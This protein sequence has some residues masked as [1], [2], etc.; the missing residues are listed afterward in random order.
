MAYIIHT[1]YIAKYIVILLLL[2]VNIQVVQAKQYTGEPI[3]LD[4]QDVDVR[5]VLRTISKY[6]N[7]NII[8]SDKVTG[9]ISLYINDVPYDQAL[10]II[11][12]SKGLGMQKTGNVMYISPTIDIAEKKRQAY[13]MQNVDDVLAPLM[14]RLI[15]L[16][17]ARAEDLERMIEDNS[18][19]ARA[20]KDGKIS[21]DGLLSSR[22]RI[23]VDKRT[24]TLIVN[25]IP[26]SINK[27]LQLVARLDIPV[28]QVLVEARIVVASNS[29]AKELG[30]RWGGGLRSNI[31]SSSL[32]IS[33]SLDGASSMALGATPSLSSRL[34]VDLASTAKNAAGLGLS[35]LGADFLL[36]LELSAMQ[37][38]GR[39]E[40]I[41]SPRVIAQDGGEASIQQGTKIAYNVTDGKGK[42][43]TTWKDI[44]L[45]LRVRP[46]IAPNNQID[47]AL[48]VVKDTPGQVFNGERSVDS[49]SVITKVLVSNGETVVLGG[50]YEQVSA[51]SQNKVPVLGDLPIIGGAFR[52]KQQSV[53]KRELLIFITPK[54]IDP[55][56]RT[57]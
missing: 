5:S 1:K 49:N 41:S 35:L 23:S 54:I 45:M 11:M 27:V 42:V 56:K 12:Q 53:V 33:G 29:F 57:F 19:N 36:D 46:K 48:E 28:K 38:E 43:T 13:E 20:G 8:I 21:T 39:G 32:G 44:P 26:A 31:G 52:H 34:G 37:D 14:Q 47:M 51:H 16:K 30:V 25:D 4:V 9:N 24:N 40:I 2:A 18:R 7:K 55:K 3:S 15:K 10:D 6:T 22:G 17:Y 50:V